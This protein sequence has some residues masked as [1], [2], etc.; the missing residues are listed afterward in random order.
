MNRA[1]DFGRV[2]VRVFGRVQG[3]YFRASTQRVARELGLFGWVRNRRDGSVELVA[4][5]PPAALD[6]LCA[7]ASVGPSIALVERLE[8]EDSQPVGLE[9]DFVIRPSV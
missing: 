6:R 3:V 4:E 2:H 8:R 1:E 7:W 9:P 5:G